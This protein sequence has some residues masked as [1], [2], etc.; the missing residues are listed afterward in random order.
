MSKQ[1]KLIK[2][3]KSHPKD[4]TFDELTNLLS[5]YGYSL[6]NK[7]KT[8]GSRVIFVNNGKDSIPIHKPHKRN[9]LLPYQIRDVENCIN[10]QEETKC[11]KK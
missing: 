11:Q 2:R 4:F 5:I 9:Y 1:E 6:D 8:S 7:G 3:F 10:K